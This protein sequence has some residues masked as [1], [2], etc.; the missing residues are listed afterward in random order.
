MSREVNLPIKPLVTNHWA[1][2]AIASYK[3]PY[4]GELRNWQYP[5]QSNRGD[6]HT[7]SDFLP[8][9]IQDQTAGVNGYE[10]DMEHGDWL[11]SGKRRR[12]RPKRVIKN[13]NAPK[14]LIKGRITPASKMKAIAMLTG[15]DFSKNGHNPQLSN[16]NQVAPMN[17]APTTTSVSHQ[18]QS[19]LPSQAEMVQL[20]EQSALNAAKL[21]RTGRFAPHVINPMDRPQRIVM[22]EKKEGSQRSR[23]GPTQSRNAE[24]QTEIETH[25]D[26]FA[27]VPSV[28]QHRTPHTSPYMVTQTTTAPQNLLFRETSERPL[29]PTASVINKLERILPDT[30]KVYRDALQRVKD[31]E[32]KVGNKP[33]KDYNSDQK[34]EKRP[35]TMAV[36]AL[37]TELK[38]AYGLDIDDII[39]LKRRISG[40]GRHKPKSRH[41]GGAPPTAVEKANAITRDAM[42]H[43]ARILEQQPTPTT[44]TAGRKRRVAKKK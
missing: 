33:V 12:K 3:I 36:T 1:N 11:G 9:Q 43:S 4:I 39:N 23:V 42:V 29:A 27:R 10:E 21:E 30:I 35:L 37:E 6:N 26:A 22:V 28:S 16:T 17:Y 15:A 14:R 38:T 40:T 32:I 31:F 8:F 25:G 5:N 44:T 24:I 20:V 41:I 34:T 2:N 18:V 19:K 7:V 13:P